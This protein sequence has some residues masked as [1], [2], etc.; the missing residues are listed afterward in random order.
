MILVKPLRFAH[1]GLDVQTL[2]VLPVLLQQRHEEVHGEA[3]VLHQLL[4]RHVHVADLRHHICA[5]ADCYFHFQLTATLRHNTFFIWNLMVAFTSF[6]FCSR[7]S[8]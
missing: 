5:N 3:D 1:G 2:D 8:E 4:L 7:S 6:T